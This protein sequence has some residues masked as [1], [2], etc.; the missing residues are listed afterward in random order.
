M[1]CF[2]Y[3]NAH[4]R[5]WEIAEYLHQIILNYVATAML[6]CYTPPDLLRTKLRA[7]S[8]EHSGLVVNLP[9]AALRRPLTI[10][11]MVLSIAL[12]SVLAWLRHGDPRS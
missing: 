7:F 2:H 10:V 6:P 4:S 12:A 3:G 11:V 8:G 1:C 9:Q 5:N